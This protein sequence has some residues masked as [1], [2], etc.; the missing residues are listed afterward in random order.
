MRILVLGGGLVGV[1]S[2]WYLSEDGHEVTVVDRQPGVALETSFANGGQISTSHAEPWAN[3]ET[4]WKAL[5]WLGRED[6]PLLWRLR[7]D[8]AQLAWGLRFLRECT[9]GRTRANIVAILR[10]ALYSRALL[11]SLR[12]A[13][14]LQYDQQ[15][16]GILHFYTDEAEFAH[17]MPQ[18]ALMRD[19]GCE[20][21]VKTASEC[22]AIEPALAGSTVPIVGG[23]FTAG[24]ESGDAHSFTQGLADRAAARGVAFRLGSSVAALAQA[25]GRVTG[26]RLANGETLTA[27]AYVVALGS[28]SPLL[29]KPLGL[30]VPVYPAKGYSA[31]FALPGGSVAPTVSLTDDG[32]KIVF[33]RLGERLRVAGTAEFTGYDTSLNDVRCQALVRR[34]RAIFPQLRTDQVEFWAGLRPATPSNVPLIGGTRLANLYLNTGHGTL[35]WTMACGTGKLLAD[36]V[37][38]RAP[39]IDPRPYSV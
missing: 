31:T 2:A 24:D 5:Q 17:A 4:P 16:R 21:L 15:E 37:G 6:S 1:A 22:L 9:P 14:G 7:A 30:G 20:R 13:L 36:L 23:T 19:Y 8:P 32:H 28:Y 18:A 35:G 10:I 3:P 38:G 39:E 29:L 27:D 33:S 26:V 25:G 12:P 34:T 11:K